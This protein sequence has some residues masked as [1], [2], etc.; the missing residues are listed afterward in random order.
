[1]LYI[2]IFAYTNTKLLYVNMICGLFNLV[3]IISSDDAENKM[4]SVGD[5]IYF[6]IFLIKGDFLRAFGK[7]FKKKLIAFKKLHEIFT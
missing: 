7:F 5:F 4:F 6:F 1:M 2:N 3:N